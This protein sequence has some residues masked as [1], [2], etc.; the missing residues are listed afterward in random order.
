M[1]SNG[2][3]SLDEASESDDW[4]E[5]YNPTSEAIDLTGFYLT[6]NQWNLTKWEIPAGTILNP[7]S[8]LIVWA[9]EDGTQGDYHANFKLSAEGE[10]VL[11]M[12]NNAEIADAVSYE[13]QQQN[14]GYA[15]NPNGTGPFVIQMHTFNA[16]NTLNVSVRENDVMASIE[17]FP[18][19]FR[20]NLTISYNQIL[21]DDATIELLDL[22]GRSVFLENGRTLNGSGSITLE[23]SDLATGSY[24]LKIHTSDRLITKHLIKN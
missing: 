3:A 11:L 2:G 10:T 8:Y 1:A 17:A 5:L 16:N 19:P 20:G 6:D 15:R 7:D 14:M 21:A 24:I 18:N 9:D 4:I 13:Q 23:T 22:S 12:N